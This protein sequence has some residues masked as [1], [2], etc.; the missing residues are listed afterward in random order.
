MGIRGIEVHQG[1]IIGATIVLLYLILNVWYTLVRRRDEGY[2][3][4]AGQWIIGVLFGF[5]ICLGMIF[6]IFAVP[7][8]FPDKFSIGGDRRRPE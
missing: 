1:V 6:V 2:S 8:V 3:F 7:A 5:P 4:T